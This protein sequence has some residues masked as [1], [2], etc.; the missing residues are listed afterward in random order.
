MYVHILCV[1]VYLMRLQAAEVATMPDCAHP[2][3]KWMFP[4]T[5]LNSH[6][7]IYKPLRAP[8]DI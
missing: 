5:M 6:V 7:A 3:N 2:P 4:N 1:C 8:R